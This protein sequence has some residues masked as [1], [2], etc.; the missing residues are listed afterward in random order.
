VNTIEVMPL[1][2]TPGERN[3]GYD[4]VHPFALQHAY[5]RPD[6]LRHFITAAHERG[7]AVLVDVIYNH[8][9]PEGNYLPQFF[10]VFTGQHKTPWGPAINF[11]DH[12]ADGVRNYWLENVRLWLRDYGADGLRLDAVHA[13]KDYSAE[14]FLESV[15]KVAD[16]ISREQDRELI[17]LAECDL[18]APRYVRPRP[19]GGYGLDGQWVDEFH[20]ALHTLLTGESRGY[21]EDFG[22][23]KELAAALRYGYVYRGQY[24]P[25]RRRNFGT[26]DYL[27]DKAESEATTLHPNQFVVFLQN[28]DQVGNRMIGDRLLSS[29]TTERYLL[30]AGVYLFSPFTPLIF[31]G[32]EYGERNP[33]PYFVHHG[34]KDLIR[35]VRKGR[36]AEFAAFQEEGK[37]VPDPQAKETF[38]S[39]KLS[40]KTEGPIAEFYR[41]AL[42]LRAAA[43]N[44]A[45]INVE[46]EGALLSWWHENANYRCYAN[47]GKE[48][49]TVPATKV[50][51]SNMPLSPT[52]TTLDLPPNAFAALTP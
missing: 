27:P 26:E 52:M 22:G 21:Y 48:A 19:A 33:F 4:G 44:F 13:I 12:Q 35:A 28:H 38:E 10:P 30:G 5:G 17:L 15:S 39:A 20:H 23:V 24:S 7:I 36:A 8:L 6:D 50:L 25:H 34:D 42:H 40:W 3:W 43:Q 11:D 49:Y 16:R 45:D 2:Q 41:K 18:N 29:M 46:Q 32:E 9:G 14:H 51:L 31:M 47:F 1:N 37:Q